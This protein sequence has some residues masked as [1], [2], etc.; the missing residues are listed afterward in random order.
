MCNTQKFFVI[1][2]LA[3]CQ[4]TLCYVQIM[5]ANLCFVNNLFILSLSCVIL[6][7]WPIIDLM[8]C[9]TE[10]NFCWS[11]RAILEDQLLAAGNLLLS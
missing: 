4:T 1:S 5:S 10:G 2:Q 9:E 11:F 6:K 7:K 3:A 8:F